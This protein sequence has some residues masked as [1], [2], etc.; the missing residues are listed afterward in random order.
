MN[1]LEP[2]KLALLR[3][4]QIYEEYTD[5][6]HTLTQEEMSKKLENEYGISIDRKTISRNI[7]LLREAGYEIEQ[8]KVGTYLG[9]RAFADAEI[10]T[11]IDSVLSS[12]YIPS[13]YSKDLIDKL[14]ALTSKHFSS[15]VKHIHSVK[16]WNKTDNQSLFYNVELIDEAINKKKQLNFDYNK[17]G[18]DKKFHKTAN[19]QVSPYQLIIHNQRYYLMAQNEKYK[20]LIYY[21]LD[22]ITNMTITNEKLSPITSV[23]GY[24]KGISYK[25]ISSQLPY[26]YSDTP[27]RVE[28]IAESHLI[29]DIIEWFGKDLTVTSIDDNHIKVSLMVSKQAMNIW[30]LQYCQ[31]MEITKPKDLRENV[32]NALMSAAERYK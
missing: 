22:H 23:K 4:L 31:Y 30:A 6:D 25:N 7:S 18:I 29:D 10:R 13:K 27:E 16:N 1:N 2:K 21:R 15:H 24:E 8:G 5:C 19:H 3:M 11:L 32:K 28:F 14:C 17:Y 26:M 12:K 20:S 9:E